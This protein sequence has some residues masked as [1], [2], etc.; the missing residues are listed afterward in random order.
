MFPTF[1]P[2]D[3]L[4]GDLHSL[5]SSDVLGVGLH[6]TEYS[7]GI[8]AEPFSCI[9][10]FVDVTDSDGDVGEYPDLLDGVQFEYSDGVQF[11]YG[12]GSLGLHSVLPSVLAG[13]LPG[14]VGLPS[15]L[16]GVL[17]G[18]VGIPS[19]P[20]G[21]VGVPSVPSGGGFIGP[22]TVSVF[23]GGDGGS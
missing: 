8:V 16:L 1:I 10:I 15:V 4:L 19:V 13:V 20:L 11:P 22:P 21:D 6:I 9:E 7:D 5:P 2:D 17:P 18:D 3:V 12:D 23:S 14:D